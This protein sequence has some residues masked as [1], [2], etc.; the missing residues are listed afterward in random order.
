LGRVVLTLILRNLPSRA[1]FTGCCKYCRAQAN[2]SADPLAVDY[3]YPRSL[4]GPTVAENPAL[5]CIGCNQNKA[6]RT[7][8]LDP[9]T[10]IAAL[11]FNPRT[12]VW[13]EYFI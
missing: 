2:Y 6:N 11:L 8:Y 10:L 3:I 12:Q 5:A 7:Q 13:P 4:G 9:V 1:L